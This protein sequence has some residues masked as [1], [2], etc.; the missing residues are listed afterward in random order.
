MSVQIQL[1]IY[2]YFQKKVDHLINSGYN[3]DGISS[4]AKRSMAFGSY[5]EVMT[6]YRTKELLGGR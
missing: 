6:E 4:Y 2:R 5:A 3:I 1:A